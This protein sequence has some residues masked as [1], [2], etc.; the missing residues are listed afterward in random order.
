M[1]NI[2][3]ISYFNEIT[4]GIK[5]LKSDIV[6][7]Y[8]DKLIGTDNTNT[9]IKVYKMNLEVPLAPVSIITKELSSEF[10]SNITDT[11]IIFDFDQCKIYCP[12]N[13][14]Y[15]DNSKPILNTIITPNLV[16][17]YNNLN[18]EL[19]EAM[20]V[21]DI[22]SIDNDS[23]FDYIKSLKAADGAKLYCPFGDDAYGMYLYSGA[24]P[25]TK[26]DKVDLKI[27]NYGITFIGNFTVYKK[28]LNPIN[29]YFKFVKMNKM[30]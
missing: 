15:A 1:I 28:K 11:E 5:A 22:G 3:N 14:S 26:S 4:T 17:R 2:I 12:N 30:W 18:L 13:K 20:S 21:I 24:L 8:G 9:N 7:I 23:N 6:C 27:Y 29:V 16:Y 10:F 19:G 25:L